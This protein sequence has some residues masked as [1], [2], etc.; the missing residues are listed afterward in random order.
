MIADTVETGNR[1]AE[2]AGTEDARND[3]ASTRISPCDRR[4]DASQA[5]EVADGSHAA[6]HEDSRASGTRRWW[7]QWLADVSVGTADA[8]RPTTATPAAATVRAAIGDVRFVA[9]GNT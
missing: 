3:G 4:T 5:L 6:P 1:A 7:L 9:A 2:E 8:E